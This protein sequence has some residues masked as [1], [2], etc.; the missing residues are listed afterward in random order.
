[1]AARSA[2]VLAL[3]A[4]LAGEPACCGAAAVWLREHHLDPWLLPTLPHASCCSNSH[5]LTAPPA[6]LP[7]CSRRPR[8]AEPLQR[9]PARH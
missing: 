6:H 5:A 2:L 7:P 8:D 4:C 3:V 9:L 1:M